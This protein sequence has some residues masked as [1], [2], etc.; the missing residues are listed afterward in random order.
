LREILEW[1]A[2]SNGVQERKKLYVGE[3]D[4]WPGEDHGIPLDRE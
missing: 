3:L 1:R 4:G 2:K